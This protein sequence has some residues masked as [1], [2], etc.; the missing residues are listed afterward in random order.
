MAV[1]ISNRDIV[2]LGIFFVGKLPPMVSESDWRKIG[3]L[4]GGDKP[5]WK[6]LQ[7]MVAE[8]DRQ[9]QAQGRVEIYQMRA[10]RGEAEAAGDTEAVAEIDRRLQRGVIR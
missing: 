2:D 9:R 3:T 6:E 8:Q 4:P 1:E 7:A 5:S 10:A